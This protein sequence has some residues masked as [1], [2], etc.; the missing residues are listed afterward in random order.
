MPTREFKGYGRMMVRGSRQAKHIRRG[1]D[2]SKRGTWRRGAG[3]ETLLTGDRASRL[4]AA[5]ST[6][7]AA[8]RPLSASTIAASSRLAP[9]A[10]ARA[11][12]HT[13]IALNC[14]RRAQVL[15]YK[16]DRL[17]FQVPDLAGFTLKPYVARDTPK[18][19][20]LK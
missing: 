14:V 19:A 6:T 17:L 8:A 13:H 16:L 11:H 20:R 1:N 3:G 9:H 15:K 18:I 12:T 2:H 10:R 4:Q 7:R 5:R